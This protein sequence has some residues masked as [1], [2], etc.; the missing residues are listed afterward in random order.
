MT[1]QAA[2]VASASAS[3]ACSSG[4]DVRLAVHRLV[5]QLAALEALAFGR[6]WLRKRN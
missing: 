3:A 1:G 4:G 5:T 2:A 6:W